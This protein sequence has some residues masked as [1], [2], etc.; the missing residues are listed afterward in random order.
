MG[1]DPLTFPPRPPAAGWTPRQSLSDVAAGGAEVTSGAEADGYLPAGVQPASQAPVTPEPRFTASVHGFVWRSRCLD[2]ASLLFRSFS[3]GTSS[4]LQCGSRQPHGGRGLG[5]KG[6]EGD[7]DGWERAVSFGKDL[8]KDRRSRWELSV[9]SSGGSGP[10]CRRGQA[11]A[12]ELRCTAGPAG[13]GIGQHRR[14]EQKEPHTL[15]SLRRAGWG[16][17]V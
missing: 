16:E 13:G 8:R 5:R 15:R 17:Q 7:V 6:R 14:P 10:G 2:C 9:S 12:A 1:T 3:E 11:W 4:W